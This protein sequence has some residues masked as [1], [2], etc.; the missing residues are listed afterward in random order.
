MTTSSQYR[1]MLSEMHRNQ[2]GWGKS[3]TVPEMA[4]W[5]I[6]KYKVESLV[7]FGCGKGLVTQELKRQFPDVDVVGY[8][9]AVAESSLPNNTDMIFSKDVLEH[10]EP[11]LLEYVLTDLYKRT[12]KVQYHLIAC[13]KALHFLPDGRNAHLIIE[14]PDW[15]Q[16]LFRSLGF[17]I[18]REEVVGD[19]KK[20]RGR[21]TIA[22]TKYHCAIDFS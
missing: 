7:D 11:N 4:K 21:E 9:P 2:P 16:R 22:T 5:C 19:I 12:N 18:V 13:H 20:P 10:I 1:D 14:T 3:A 8:D 6:S 15:W 17:R